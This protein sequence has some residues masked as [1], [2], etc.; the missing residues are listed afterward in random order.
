[1]IQAWIAVFGSVDPSRP[2]LGIRKPD[3]AR[4]AAQSIGRAL[5]DRSCGIVVYSGDANFIEADVVAG[6]VLSDK[7]QPESVRVIHARKSPQPVLRS[8]KPSRLVSNSESTPIP[9]GRFPSIDRCTEQT[10]SFS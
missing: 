5:A 10:E 9:I 2:A 6:F 7:A 1:M 8:S 3:L 4:A